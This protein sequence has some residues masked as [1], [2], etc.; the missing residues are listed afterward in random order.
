MPVA[1]PSLPPAQCISFVANGTAQTPRNVGE[2]RVPSAQIGEQIR[3]R[4]ALAQT[5]F[6]LQI[7]RELA[8]IVGQ[9]I[10]VKIPW[11]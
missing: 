4:M 8:K 2:F 6:A 10:N 5:R 3:R 1:A 11:H 7:R 9:F